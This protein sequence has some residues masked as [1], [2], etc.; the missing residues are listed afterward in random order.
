MAYGVNFT[1][2]NKVFG[3]PAGDED[4]VDALPAMSNGRFVTTCWK[5]SDE[6]LSEVNKTGLVFHTVLSSTLAPVFIGSSKSTR[7]I[8]ADCGMALPQQKVIA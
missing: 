4:R 6:E 7:S 1:G 2:A 5:L 3:P 8:T